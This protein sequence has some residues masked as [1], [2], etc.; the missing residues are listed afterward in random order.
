MCYN[1]GKSYAFLSC[2]LR[3]SLSFYHFFPLRKDWSHSIERSWYPENSVKLLSLHAWNTI[4]SMQR[5][6]ENSFLLNCWNEWTRVKRARNPCFSTGDTRVY[7]GSG[8]RR[9]KPYVQLSVVVLLNEQGS[10]GSPRRVPHAALYG[11]QRATSQWTW[12]QV[13]YNMESNLNWTT[14]LSRDIRTGGRR[15][16][17]SGVLPCTPSLV[18]VPKCE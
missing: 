7:T 14:L 5:Y 2:Y 18:E 15:C 9:V 11:Q 16:T 13:G 10:V 6:R 3:A 4:E 17:T 12:V 1:L 8:L